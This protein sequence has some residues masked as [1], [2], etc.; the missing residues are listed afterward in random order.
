MSYI[1]PR[2]TAADYIEMFQERHAKPYGMGWL[3][4]TWRKVTNRR[5]K[6][7]WLANGLPETKLY[8]VEKRCGGTSRA[9]AN[10]YA[11]IYGINPD[12]LLISAGYIPDRFVGKISINL[13]ARILDLLEIET[14]QLPSSPLDPL[15][16]TQ[17]VRL[18]EAT[19]E[20]D[21]HA[22]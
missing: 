17:V 5:M 7:L 14:K 4:R 10:V 18:A 2:R 16:V 19:H 11:K 22:S 12:V 3:L 8:F 6:D 21:Q 20:T 1:I 13:I 15:A 9:Q